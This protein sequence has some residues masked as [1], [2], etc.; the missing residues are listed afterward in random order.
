[1]A[2]LVLLCGLPG[3]GKTTVARE[4]AAELG[5]IR[6]CPDEWMSALELDLFDEPIRAR[7][8][9]VQWSLAQELLQ[10]GVSVVIEWG[11]WA[12]SERD[13]VRER[14]REL[15]VPVELHYLDVPLDV[16]WER[17]RARND[18][19]PPGTAII[20]Y[21]NLVDWS[22]HL[23]EPPTAEEQALFDPPSSRP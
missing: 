8:E 3:S 10:R 19:G 2:R 6:F 7:I 13:T 22:E 1:M 5:A 16:L 20:S 4:L 14:A 18:S 17:V 12:R 11:V 21:E 23:F 9:S 15:G